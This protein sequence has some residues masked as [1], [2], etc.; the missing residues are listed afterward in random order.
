MKKWILFAVLAVL[1]AQAQA[2]PRGISQAPLNQFF[3]QPGSALAQRDISYG[4][5][6]VNRYERTITLKLQPAWHCPAGALCAMVMPQPIEI[7]V[8]GL[9]IRKGGCG[10]T[11]Y[12]AEENLLPV[13]GPHHSLEVI[14]NAYNYCEVYPLIPIIVRYA[15]EG[16]RSPAQ[17]HVLY[18]SEF[19]K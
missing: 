1:G 19:L 4:H 11:I 5:V 13:D 17:E 12:R 16:P 15:S 10:E 7:E 9:Q 8:S 2:E 6:T 3:F 14:D 18:G